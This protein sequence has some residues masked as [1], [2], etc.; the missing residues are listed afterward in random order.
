MNTRPQGLLPSDTENP[1]PK[2][3]EH[4]KAF[5][6]RSGKQTSEPV[7]YST[8]AS[9]DIG[10]INPDRKVD[11]EELVDV[12]D[13][14]VPPTVVHMPY[15][16]PS[17]LWMQLKVS[18]QPNVLL[19]I[20]FPQRFKRNENYKQY[21]QFLHTLEQLQ[22]NIP[23]VDAPVQISNYRKFMKDLLSKKKK[24]TDVETIA[25]TEGCSTVLINKFP[26]KLKDPGSFTIPCLIGK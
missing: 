15:I 20:P 24:L 21:Q 3:K 18:P 26:P 13:K 25:L 8:V 6:L 19:S 17:K 4:Y 11:A 22:I 9:P 7:I 12:P 10:D 2:G 23:L 5:T 14:E 1:S 16:R